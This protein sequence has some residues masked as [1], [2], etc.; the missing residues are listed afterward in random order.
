MG[1]NGVEDL[2]AAGVNTANDVVAVGAKGG[3]QP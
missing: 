2:A 3:R 1:A